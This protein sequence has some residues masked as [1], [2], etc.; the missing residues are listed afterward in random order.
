MVTKL[1]E[2]LAV[3]GGLKGQAEKV[4]GD[5]ATTF[6]KKRHHFSEKT[7][8]FQPS[9]ETEKPVTEEQLDLQATVRKELA[10]IA[11]IWSE[12]LDVSA[13]VAEANTRARADVVLASGQVVFKDL[14]ATALLELEKRLLEVHGLV[15][16]IPTLDPARG[17]KP[18]AHKGEGIYKA[19]DD[20]KTRT[21]K[22]QRA[23]V[24]YP[25]TP[26][27][28]AQTQLISEDVPVGKILTQE[29]S[30]LITPSE[31]ADMLERAEELRRAVKAARSRAN[32]VE[33]NQQKVGG[34]LFEYIFNGK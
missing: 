23:I 27:H 13:A 18:D 33:V 31:K 9:E 34:K 21:K 2:L 28:P 26:E 14:P 11:G 15:L 3:E 6:E 16:A 8:T 7:V 32:E 10:W 4:R 29:W 12:A 30:G 19:R 22:V 24:L 17:F 1:H 5:L 20:E 25:A